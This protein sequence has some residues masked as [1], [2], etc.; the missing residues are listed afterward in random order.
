M[1]L[2]VPMHVLYKSQSAGFVKVDL[3]LSKGNERVVVET[4]AVLTLTESHKQQ[5]RNYVR[6]AG[7]AFGVLINFSQKGTQPEVLRI[8]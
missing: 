1:E 7:H 5:T 8:Q 3:I 2:E 4:K 6:L